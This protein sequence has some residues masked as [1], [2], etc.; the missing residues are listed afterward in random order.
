MEEIQTENQNRKLLLTLSSRMSIFGKILIVLGILYLI[1]GFVTIKENYGNIFEGILQIFLGYLTI[2]V[3]LSFKHAAAP[4]NPSLE[5]L[6]QALEAN[7]K[8]Y[9]WQLYVYGFIFFL[10]LFTFL[11]LAWT[12]LS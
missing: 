4:E 6:K 9:H 1:G 2:R 5:D 3:S 11:S 12:N 10:V 7:I 8:L